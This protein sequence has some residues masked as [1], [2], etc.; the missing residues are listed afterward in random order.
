MASLLCE[1]AVC[2]PAPQ[3]QGVGRTVRET[4]G[5]RA[6]SV[7][8]GEPAGSYLIGGVPVAGEFPFPF[9]VLAV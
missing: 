4:Q 8:V 6:L 9:S 2:N 3:M 5:C 1:A 7:E